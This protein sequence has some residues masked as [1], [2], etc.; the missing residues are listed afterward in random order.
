MWEGV[1]MSLDHADKDHAELGTEGFRLS[2]GTSG[3]HIWPQEGACYG[4][5]WASLTHLLLFFI[6]LLSSIGLL[7]RRMGEVIVHCRRESLA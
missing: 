3:R 2:W 4:I 1:R 5:C 7:W 6:H